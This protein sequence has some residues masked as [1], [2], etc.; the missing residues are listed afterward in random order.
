MRYLSDIKKLLFFMLKSPS[1][2]VLVV[3][4]PP[5]WGMTASTRKILGELGTEYH[6]LG[7]YSTPLALFNKLADIVV[8]QEKM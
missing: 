4:G 8:H 1:H 6:M 3:S 2:H 5:G 7:A